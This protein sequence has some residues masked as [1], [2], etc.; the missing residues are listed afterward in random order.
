MPFDVPPQIHRSMCFPEVRGGG[1]PCA[2]FYSTN[3]TSC[4]WMNLQTILMRN[5]SIGWNSIWIATKGQSSLS[6]TTGTSWIM[7]QDGFWNST[8]E[9]AFLSRSE[10]HTS[11]L[12]SRGN[13]VC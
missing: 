5:L 7:W 6:P 1:W 4:F 11:E 9:R 12:Q 10:E 13:L 3:Q 2:G 8:G